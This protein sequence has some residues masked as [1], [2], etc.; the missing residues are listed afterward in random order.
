MTAAK[1][2][3][4]EYGADVS[5]AEIARRAGVGPT[6]LYRHF[7]NKDALVEALLDDLSAGA[8]QIAERARALDDPWE[9][10]RLVFTESCVLSPQD[11]TL[12]DL[13]SRHSPHAASRARALTA[14][15]VG[16]LTARAQRA[17]ELRPDIDAQDVA[18]LMRLTDVLPPGPQRRKALEVLLDG[19][20][21]TT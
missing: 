11:L 12:F 8:L 4:T 20:R 21:T 18:A 1:D 19:L 2:V 15:V 9:A 17:G 7:A 14:D 3:L 6:T 5:L 10:F 13:L 16:P